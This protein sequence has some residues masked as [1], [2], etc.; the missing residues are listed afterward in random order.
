MVIVRTARVLGVL[1]LFQNS[2]LLTLALPEG[3]PLGFVGGQHIT[4]DT[5]ETMPDG[6]AAHRAYAIVSADAEQHTITLAVQT[7]GIG[8]GA[9]YMHG[10]KEGDDVRFM[11]PAGVLRPRGAAPAPTLVC[12][13]D[14]GI[15]A[16]LGLVR[17]EGFRGLRAHT[18]FVWLKR[19]EACV[20][21]DSLVRDYLPPG[22]PHVHIATCANASDVER[23][24]MA[25][26]T[27]SATPSYNNAYLSCDDAINTAL[28]DALSRAGTHPDRILRETV[29]DAP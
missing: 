10:L 26:H 14:S 27:T 19:E 21:P 28:G 4:V 8:P 9:A 20:L 15:S 18:D 7:T 17:G 29:L 24:Q 5:G 11:G 22:M 3:E 1:P 6:A 16:A 12:A 25:L 13:T 23:T 2:R